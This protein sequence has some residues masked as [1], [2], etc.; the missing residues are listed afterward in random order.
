M[1]VVAVMVGWNVTGS[2]PLM[3]GWDVPLTTVLVHAKLVF[4]SIASVV[5]SGD[6]LKDGHMQNGA[7][8]FLRLR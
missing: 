4:V 2:M 6:S 3:L 7:R 8:L 5:G 1:A